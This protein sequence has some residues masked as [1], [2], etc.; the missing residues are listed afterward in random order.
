MVDC[1]YQVLLLSGGTLVT[2]RGAETNTDLQTKLVI[3]HVKMPIKEKLHKNP[4]REKC[5]ETS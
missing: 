2:F 3:Y 5:G 1:C 4:L